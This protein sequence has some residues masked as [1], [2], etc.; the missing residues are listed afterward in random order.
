MPQAQFVTR[1]QCRE[2]LAHLVRSPSENL[3]LIDL[4]QEISRTWRD[5][6]GQV[7]AAWE[8]NRVVG[9][10]SL[11]PSIVTDFAMSSDALSACLPL[12]MCVEMGLI[13][14]APEHAELIWDGLRVRGRRALIDRRET[15]YVRFLEDGVSALMPAPPEVVLRKARM[16]DLE[17]LIHA[18]RASLLEESRPDPFDGDMAG[19]RRWV[20]GRVEQA[21]LVEVGG[22]TVFVAYAD[23]RQPDG[24]LVQGVYTW[25]GARRRG[26]ARAGMNA[27]LAEA[28]GRGATHVQLAVV[29]GN[30][31]AAAL[32]AGLGFAPRFDLRTILFS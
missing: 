14:T 27:L 25:P 19:F 3:F 7:V 10:A 2:V 30:A 8:G 11:R 17:S 4:V 5:P 12:L 18:A 28:E 16:E 1:K 31:P 32:Y 24:W 22:K 29:S 13:K 15:G 21:R 23:V 26:Y 6:V 20:A 9:V